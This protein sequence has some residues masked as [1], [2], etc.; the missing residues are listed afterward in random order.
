MTIAFSTESNY[1]RFILKLLRYYFILGSHV[2]MR[3][4]HGVELHTK[5]HILHLILEC[6]NY[7]HVCISIFL[8]YKV[9]VYVGLNSEMYHANRWCT[10]SRFAPPM[11][12]LINGSAVFVLLDDNLSLTY[13][14]N[15]WMAQSVHTNA[16][17]GSSKLQW[18]THNLKHM[19]HK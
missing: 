12:P 7:S 14:M 18:L 2:R 11:A 3:R 13:A 15:H 9:S 10:D 17:H 8:F 16:L 1:N 5:L 4:A 6:P 19:G